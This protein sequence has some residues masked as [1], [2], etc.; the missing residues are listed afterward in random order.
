MTVVSGA[1]LS[2]SSAGSGELVALDVATGK[3]EWKKQLPQPAYG[4][5][6]VVNDLVFET[7]FDGVV[8]ALDAKSG[9][10]VWQ[11]TLPAGINT[12]VVANGEFLIAPAGL[13]IAEGQTPEI[14]AFRL[15]G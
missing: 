6:T 13:P 9:G 8:Y 5:P 2:E 10:E 12:G 3:V 15:P 14:V 7:T 4:A 1:E 11:A